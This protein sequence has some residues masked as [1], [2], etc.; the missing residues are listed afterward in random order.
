MSRRKPIPWVV[1]LA[2]LTEMMTFG[3]SVMTDR[4][5]ICRDASPYIAS[6]LI[7]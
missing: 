2:F 7:R 3:I 5:K 4:L 1:T 6:E